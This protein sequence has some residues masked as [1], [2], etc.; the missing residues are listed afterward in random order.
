MDFPFENFIVSA[1]SFAALHAL[2]LLENNQGM[3][4]ILLDLKRF[5]EEMQ[6]IERKR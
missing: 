1:E 3:T 6:K 4:C 2:D 5:T